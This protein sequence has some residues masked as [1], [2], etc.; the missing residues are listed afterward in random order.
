MEGNETFSVNLSEPV[1][2]TYNLG[3]SSA[4]VTIVDNET[5]T[6]NFSS[7]TYSVDENGAN[8]T[9]TLLRNGNV[10]TAARVNVTTVAGNAT[11]NSDYVTTSRSIDFAQGQTTAT[12]SVPILDDQF[13]EGTEF[14]Q[15][16]LSAQ[17]SSGAIIGPVGLATVYILDDEPADTVAGAVQFGNGTYGV[18][19]NAG[20][21]TLSVLLNR[22][23]NTNAPASVQYATVAGSAGTNR[24]TPTS[25]T[26][27]FAPGT[28]VA[29][30]TVPIIND[31]VL[32]PPQNFAVVLSN[33]VNAV[34]A[35]PSSATV[36]IQDDDGINTVQFEQ[37]TYGAIE[38]TLV[39][40]NGVATLR[41]RAVRGADP[42]QVL[43][44]GLAFGP[45][46]PDSA[47]PG[48]DYE[49]P[50]NTTV[51]FPPGTSSQT[52]D[53]QLLNR[54]G[55]QGNRSFTVS[56]QNP[57]AF[58][59]VG[60]QGS[61]RVT[62]FD[63]SGSNTVQFTTSAIRFKENEQ[64]AIA[65]QVVRYGQ[66]TSDAGGTTVSYTTDIRNGDTAQPGINF[67]ATSRNNHISDDSRQAGNVI[68][69]EQEK[70]IIILVPDN[71]LIQGDATFH[72][73][74]LFADNA[75]FGDISTTQV[76]I[77]DDD[78]GNVIQFSSANFSVS[79]S[80][81]NAVLTLNLTPNGDASRASSVNYAA[82]GITAFGGFDFSPVTGT[83]TFAPGERSK[84]ILVPINDDT[85]V[86]D[87]ETFRVTLSNP[88]P[89]AIIGN[90][91]NA[92]VTIID[93][94]TGPNPTPTP[95]EPSIVSFSQESFSAVTTEAN[96]SLTVNLLRAA[97]DTGTFSVS[98]AT[99]D[100]SAIAGRDYQQSMGTATFASGQSQQTITIPLLP[101]SFPAAGGS[102]TVTLS[103]PSRGTVGA[104]ARAT[105]VFFSPDLSTK[106]MNISTRGPV[107]TGNDVMIAGF[108]IQGDA[109][110]QVVL[111]GIGPS[112]GP[113][114]VANAIADPTLTLMDANGNQ[115]AFN[116]DY[117]ANSLVDQQTI[118]ANGLTPGDSREAAI[119]ASLTPGT[120]TAI[121]RG[122]TN[123]IG[124]VEAYDISATASSHFVNISTRAKVEQGDNG[125]L[126]AGFI[127]APPENQPGTTRR[128]VIRAVGPTL[129]NFGITNALADPTLDIYRGSQLILSN[130][131]WKS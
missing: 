108:I 11:A 91:P 45:A 102:F 125:A 63:D 86:E 107:E 72:V 68:A 85:L 126:I 8:V 26:L 87:S 44:V 54:V 20:S 9:L 34:L 106:L 35:V 42:N 116:D 38:D 23:G 17:Q 88:S 7:S 78:L 28:A 31:S 119:L 52:V 112:L 57:G 97:G 47:I 69:Q 101:Q 113:L 100:G 3:N 118:A 10:N 121:L 50:T 80:G 124:L 64:Q 53:I 55:A 81:G 79:E 6:V 117:A 2:Q 24:F 90:P 59:T 40:D 5:S 83:V 111:R 70:T 27:N 51:T 84:T 99:Q 76:T 61:A 66:F 29:T 48:T 13:V 36:T 43:T 39:G 41:L 115:L 114:G 22:T 56:L 131:N 89:G 67:I 92:I 110:E 30:I 60:Q 74:L 75:Q 25:G 4:T 128:V 33:P 94:D 16:A 14:F 18:L 103:N 130:D 129:S 120:Y 58:T 82:T 49:L 65:L 98:Y 46:P 93:D 104:P 1:G 95:G 15:I 12:F 62:I 127:I 105:V 96:V 19:E 77:N 109:V 32:E 123:G 122:K 71:A 37:A 21:I 73:T